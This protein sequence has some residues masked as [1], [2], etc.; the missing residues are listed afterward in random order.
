MEIDFF[1]FSG[2]PV[3]ESYFSSSGEIVLNEFFIPYSG[4]GFSVLWKPFPLIY[5]FFL[6]VEAI[7][8]KIHFFGKDFILGSTKGFAVE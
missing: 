2:T 7:T 6:Q 5:F 1:H 8:V 3:R 4:D